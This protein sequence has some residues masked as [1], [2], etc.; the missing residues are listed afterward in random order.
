MTRS[1]L[2][3]NFIYFIRRM[4]ALFENKAAAGGLLK[5]QPPITT[6]IFN[7]GYFSL[8]NPASATVPLAASKS[9][10][11]SSNST[12]ARYRFVNGATGRSLGRTS[13]QP[14]VGARRSKYPM[15]REYDS[16]SVLCCDCGRLYRVISFRSVILVPVSCAFGLLGAILTW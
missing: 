13:L 3:I 2:W 12:W 10:N 16:A 1:R 11:F 15:R 5:S 8:R 9:S 7:P 14:L 6:F 4:Y